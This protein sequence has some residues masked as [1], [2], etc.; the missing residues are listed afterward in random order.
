MFLRTREE[1]ASLDAKLMLPTRGT[2]W[3]GT[4]NVRVNP[5]LLL[6]EIRIPTENM[7]HPETFK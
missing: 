2:V 1:E 6:L 4:S 7:T 5:C 3:D